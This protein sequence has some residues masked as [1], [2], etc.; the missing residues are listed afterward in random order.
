MG[1][2][3]LTSVK[4]G[5]KAFEN[6]TQSVDLS[7]LDMSWDFQFGKVSKGTE[8]ML[9]EGHGYLL[10]RSFQSAWQSNLLLAVLRVAKSLVK[11]NVFA[12]VVYTE[13]WC[14]SIQ[15]EITAYLYVCISG[16]SG[17]RVTTAPTNGQQ[18]ST[19]E[20]VVGADQTTCTF[21]NLNPGVEY[22]VSVYSVKDDQ[23]SIPISETVTQGN[24]RMSSSFSYLKSNCWARELYIA[25][26]L[27]AWWRRA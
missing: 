18:G 13:A 9:W 22:N 10:G 17:Y 27:L 4:Q 8:T 6:P 3:Q 12:S 5:L 25:E 23:E 11:R 21:E 20:E 7:F 14:K 19:L 15:H 16:I 2:V 24:E 1:A 26:L